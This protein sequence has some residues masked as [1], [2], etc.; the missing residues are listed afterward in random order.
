[1]YFACCLSVLGLIPPNTTSSTLSTSSSNFSS[2]LSSSSSSSSCHSAST[3][4]T[5]SSFSISPF[6]SFSSV[7]CR[8]A[9]FCDWGQGDKNP[10]TFYTLSVEN[11]K[12]A[13]DSGSLF[14]RKLKLSCLE[15]NVEKKKKTFRNEED[16]ENEIEVEKKELLILWLQLVLNLSEK[17]SDTNGVS[18]DLERTV[19]M[20]FD[21]N[22]CM[23]RYCLIGADK[24]DITE[25][26][27]NYS[28]VQGREKRSR[29][30]D[31]GNYDEINFQNNRNELSRNRERDSDRGDRNRY[32]DKERGRDRGRDE[33]IQNND[34]F[35]YHD[36]AI[37]NH[38]LHRKN[39]N[40]NNNN[41]SSNKY[42][43]DNDNNN[44]QKN[45][46]NSSYYDRKDKYNN[47]QAAHWSTNHYSK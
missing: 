21:Y 40:N 29:T 26:R 14:F 45:S 22:Y 9:T 34:N 11:L 12:K 37:S 4:S 8:R 16:V 20:I 18:T 5:S 39:D 10:K 43:N 35:D 13:K 19:D 7:S 6:P 1:M 33:E 38:N 42:H 2:S 25:M 46:Y 3:S 15:P 24:V 36:S 27:R 23:A 41:N 28:D 30:A 31:E 44:E 32:S 47:S 17:K